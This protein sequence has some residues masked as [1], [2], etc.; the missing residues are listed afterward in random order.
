MGPNEWLVNKVPFTDA[1]LT[2]SASIA[3]PN[4]A[5][6]LAV[7]KGTALFTV[8]THHMACQGASDLCETLFSS[9]L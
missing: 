6:L 1:E 9:R 8:E 4:I 3:A 7:E 2:F 5:E